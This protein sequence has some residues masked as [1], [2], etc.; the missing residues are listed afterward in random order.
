MTDDTSLAALLGEAPTSTDPRF[1]VDVLARVKARA[2]RRSAWRR[3][4]L[5]V[6]GFTAAG[7]LAAL[8]QSASVDAGAWAPLLISAGA[9]AT[10]GS[11]ALMVISGPRAAL[12]HA[13]SAFG[14]AR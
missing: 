13:L 8:V 9:L 6:A 4:V 10:A 2:A 3:G 7:L 12:T 1:R 11:F 14:F 5:R